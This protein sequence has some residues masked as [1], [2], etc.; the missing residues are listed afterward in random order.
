MET[1]NVLE[2]AKKDMMDILNELTLKNIEGSEEEMANYFSFLKKLLKLRNTTKSDNEVIEETEKN[3]TC[4]ILQDVEIEA[5]SVVEEVSEVDETQQMIYKFERK[6]R[7]GFVP[8]IEGY[9]PEGI[10]RSLGLEDGDYI[11][12]Q[13]IESNYSEGRRFEYSFAEMGDR[14]PQEEREQISFGVVTKVAG[15]LAVESYWDGGE[16]KSVRMNGVPY[17]IMLNEVEI[18]NINNSVKDPSLKVKVGAMIDIA[19]YKGHVQKHR[20]IWVHPM[21]SV[22]I[23]SIEKRA[24]SY[25]RYTSDDVT[26]KD[27]EMIEQ[28]LEGRSILIVGDEPNKRFYKS[29]IEGRGGVFLWCSGNEPVAR[30][31]SKVR[32]SDQVI[33]LLKVTSHYGQ[34]EIKDLC[35]Q[36]GVPFDTTWNTGKSVATREAERRMS[37]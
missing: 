17:T 8:S 33:F 28:T 22:S 14:K 32:K 15:G 12:A 23:P 36:Y 1:T 35:K 3:E 20:I 27:G 31:E 26:S 5:G 18:Q 6:R 9:V 19:F 7:G 29:A 37:V 25:K 16:I 21:N 13:E 10:V 34:D 24:L 11:Y 4:D 30:L 2:N